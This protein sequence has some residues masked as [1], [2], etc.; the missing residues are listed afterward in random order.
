MKDYRRYRLSLKERGV[1]FC[2]SI[3]VTALCGWLFYDTVLGVILSPIVFVLI[4]RPI[5]NYIA[6]KRRRILRDQFRDVL[7]S[8][9]SSFAAGAH[10]EEAME[11]ALLQINEI[12]GD[13]CDM[14]KELLAMVIKIRETAGSD[15][16]LWNDLAQRSG[17]EDVEDFAR[18]FKACRDSGGNLVQA[19]DRAAGLIVEKINIENEMRT[20][21][22]Q[23]KTEGRL[24]GTMP[25]AMI[26][27]LRISSPSYLDLMYETIVGKMMMTFA[28]MAIIYS[29]YMTEKITKVDI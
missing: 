2:G 4:K 23:K 5:E 10:M 18:V 29:V 6:E 16:E 19:V 25:I 9:S 11:I 3:I 15:V 26:L 24:V 20:L 21:F 7:Y 28:A 8:F 22:S 13:N 1:V 12:Y 14:S 27:F 17:L